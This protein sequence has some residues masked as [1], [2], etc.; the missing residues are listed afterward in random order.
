MESEERA[1]NGE[2]HVVRL[3]VPTQPPM[4]DDLVYG[5]VGKAKQSQIVKNAGSATYE[6]PVILKSDGWPTY[7][8]ANVVDD[9]LMQITHVIRAV[10]WMSS[11][12]KHLLM[13]KAF[14][15]SPPK[16]AHVGLLQDSNRQKFSKR[17]M[18]SDLNVST[19]RDKGYFPETLL[20]YA[21]LF[22]WSHSARSDVLDLDSLIEQFDLKFTKGDT[23]VQPAKLDFLQKQYAMKYISTGGPNLDNIIGQVHE[24]AKT[25]LAN[26][27]P[28]LIIPEE[29]FPP[30]IRLLLQLSQN[31]Y[32]IPSNFF[33]EHFYFFRDPTTSDYTSIKS[34]K[35]PAAAYR[36]I[37][38]RSSQ[39][40]IDNCLTIINKPENL[41]QIYDL[42]HCYPPGEWNAKSLKDLAASIGGQIAD[43][44]S[45]DASKAQAAV[46]TYL[47]WAISSARQGPGMAE[48]MELL[49][50][51]V[52]V[53]R[54]RSADALM[55]KVKECMKD[56]KGNAE[57]GE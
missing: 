51:E 8:L 9:H 16:Y 44:H 49:G 32:I 26:Q 23:I 1:A 54:L 24:V 35:S 56:H 42:H 25:S 46:N 20:N 29:D 52:C 5:I 17:N 13:F 18:V 55:R 48:T 22:G 34:E 11:T 21:A 38:L 47:R 45:K 40:E 4:L 14:G 15:W 36:T 57:I 27:N 53:N 10:E 28:K 37:C 33:A 3:E 6:D 30:R 7:H 41:H 12:P 31:R 50:Q 19:F 43:E 39:P 2:L